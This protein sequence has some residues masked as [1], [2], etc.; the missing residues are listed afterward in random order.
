MIKLGKECADAGGDWVYNGW[1]GWKCEFR[2]N[3]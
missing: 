1:N 3:E 2:S